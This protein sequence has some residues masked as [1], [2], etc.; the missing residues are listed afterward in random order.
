ML[1]EIKRH[2]ASYV[3]N[4]AVR[5][6]ASN[7]SLK[8]MRSR[9]SPFRFEPIDRHAGHNVK[10]L[11][12]V[13]R[14]L[15]TIVQNCCLVVQAEFA[16]VNALI[17]SFDSS[18]FRTLEIIKLTLTSMGNINEDDATLMMQYSEWPAR[19]S[20]FF[21]I[22]SHDEYLSGLIDETL[23]SLAHRLESP[24][25][26]TVMVLRWENSRFEGKDSCHP[27][28]WNRVDADV[29]GRAMKEKPMAP[30]FLSRLQGPLVDDD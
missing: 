18:S 3:C 19:L 15:R 16:N 30:S 23:R 1:M 27:F 6:Q 17:K 9:K 21:I 26:R 22:V 25:K 28:W 14:L 5:I 11:S 7:G 29:I 12:Q 8:F 10:A 13:C 4:I 20:L 2:I 24:N